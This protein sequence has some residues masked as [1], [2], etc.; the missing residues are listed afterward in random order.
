KLDMLAAFHVLHKTKR[1][2]ITADVVE[3]A[4]WISSEFSVPITS[5]L[6]QHIEFLQ[7]L[8]PYPPKMLRFVEDAG[9]FVRELRQSMQPGEVLKTEEQLTAGWLKSASGTTPDVTIVGEHRLEVID[10]K[11][12]SIPVD[13][14]SNDQLMFYAATKYWVERLPASG[15]KHDPQE[16]TAHILQPGNFSS[17]T[18]PIQVLLDWMELAKAAD[19]RIL[20]KDVSLVPNEHCTFCPANPHARG[21]KGSPL[22]PAQRAILYPERMDEDEILA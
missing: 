4:D 18:A 15:R 22:C 1:D 6:S 9:R 20:D 10:Y 11:T 7:S 12:G 13:A 2:K 8:Q 17:W 19:Q 3:T 16:F 21:E 14:T 5:V